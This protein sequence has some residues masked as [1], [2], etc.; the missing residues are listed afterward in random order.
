MIDKAKDREA[1]HV[2]INSSDTLLQS[3]R[4]RGSWPFPFEGGMVTDVMFS[5]AAANSPPMAVLPLNSSSKL[6]QE[7]NPFEQSF[8]G[9]A[10][11]L[12]VKED[13]PETSKPML[14]SVASL[15]SPSIP[16]INSG[17][18]PKDVSNQFTWET[19]RT[20]PLSPSMLSGPA[21]PSDFNIYRTNGGVVRGRIRLPGK[22]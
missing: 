3:P 4:S 2:A 6:D 8:S 12:E 22:R 11:A 13:K 19:L 1:Q 18:L 10:A 7:P 14:P 5:S 16:L 21:N 20:G 9:A 15:T 17:V